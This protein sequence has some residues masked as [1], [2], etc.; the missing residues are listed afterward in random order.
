MLWNKKEELPIE[1][2]P[3]DELIY[4]RKRLDD[5]I[6]SR[7]TAELDALKDKLI[8]IANAQ[9][10]SLVDL[11]GSKPPKEKKERKKREFKARYRNPETG[12]E[13]TGMG[14]PKKWLQEKL[15]AGHS[16]EEF[17]VN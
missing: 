5:E 15:D 1:L 16:I 14:K 9:G 17:A 8:L 11:F 7:G 6:A 10:L 3:F 13:W 4:L 2:K 12:E